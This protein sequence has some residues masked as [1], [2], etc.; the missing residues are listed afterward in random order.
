[1]PM[2]LSAKLRA[3][4]AARL[5]VPPAE[6]DPPTLIRAPVV[7]ASPAVCAAV[8]CCAV[9]EM[10]MFPPATTP[11]VS[12]TC[13]MPPVTEAAAVN[14]SPPSI[15][16]APA[17]VSAPSAI[18][19]APT[20][21]PPIASVPCRVRVTVSLPPSPVTTS[22]VPAPSNPSSK[23]IAMLSPWSVPVID[24]PSPA[25]ITA[26]SA[27]PMRTLICASAVED[28]RI[29]P[30]KPAPT[31][32]RLVSAMSALIRMRGSSASSRKA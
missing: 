16:H 20:L 1:M 26:T 21:R 8:R 23:T 6:T 7:A 22:S 2:V 14:S 12:T 18:S 3:T 25:A 27:S 28:S 15:D 11:S 17:P 4:S 30:A 24:R 9:A 13:A 10:A 29:S 32:A 31:P 5:A 19:S